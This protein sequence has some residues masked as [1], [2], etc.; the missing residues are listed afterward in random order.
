MNAYL[1]R[2]GDG[3]N[4]GTEG[5]GGDGEEWGEHGW[6]ADELK[7]VGVGAGGLAGADALVIGAA[8]ED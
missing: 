3:R 1:G 2:D 4:S 6:G 8:D 5:G 7:S